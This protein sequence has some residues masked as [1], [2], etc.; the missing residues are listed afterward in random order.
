[1]PQ[2]CSMDVLRTILSD[3]K[4]NNLKSRKNALLIN[5]FRFLW[6]DKSVQKVFN[7]EMNLLTHQTPRTNCRKLECFVALCCA[8]LQQLYRCRTSWENMKKSGGIYTWNSSIGVNKFWAEKNFGWKII[9]ALE[10]AC[11]K[12]KGENKI[13]GEKTRRKNCE[14]FFLEN[15]SCFLLPELPRNQK[16]CF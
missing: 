14:K 9:W 5:C 2:T 4:T 10:M 7:S 16:S 11:Q 8:L 1:M 6:S 15:K 3:T 13:R 12:S